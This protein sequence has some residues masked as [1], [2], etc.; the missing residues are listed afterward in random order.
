V[1]AQAANVRRLIETQAFLKVV[2]PFA[3][4]ITSRTIER[5]DLVSETKTVELYT[6]AAIDPVRVFV[7]VPQT[8]VANV[9]PGSEA[10][11]TVREYPGRKF[12]G[13]VTRSA[14][15]L[16][17]D[18]H[19]MTTEIQVPNADAALKPGMYCQATLSFPVPHRVVEVPATA[20]Y[21]DSQ[22]LR[23]AVVDGQQKLHYVPI[24][25]ERDTGANLQ[26][27]TGLTG[28]ER[29]VKIAVPGLPEGEP[30]EVAPPKAAAPAAAPAGSAAPAK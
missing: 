20:L 25:I 19:T 4:T 1:A 2:A 15:A 12:I 27:S 14:G 21:S 3:G 28:D 10:T 6:L 9:N 23:V 5:G 17:P 7:D 13:K 11:I 24:T 18:L 16:D 26:I 29:V 8:V 30:L 22:G